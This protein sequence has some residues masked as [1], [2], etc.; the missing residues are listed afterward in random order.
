MERL[1]QIY[2]K[3]EICRIYDSYLVIG[4]IFLE[5]FHPNLVFFVIFLYFLFI[6]IG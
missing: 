1:R 3:V 6:L 5:I 4:T 2:I